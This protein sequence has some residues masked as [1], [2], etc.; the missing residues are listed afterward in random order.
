MKDNLQLVQ[1]RVSNDKSWNIGE[2]IESVL[3]WCGGEVTDLG[4]VDMGSSKVVEST[5]VGETIELIV[6]KRRGVRGVLHNNK[7]ICAKCLTGIASE[8]V[9]LDQDLIVRSGVDS[10]ETEVLVVVV[11]QMLVSKATSVTTCGKVAPVV[12]V[13]SQMKLAAINVAKFV[14][15]SNERC[16]VM[17]VKVVPGD[18]NP[19]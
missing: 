16:L 4:N 10:L 14:V 15:V 3:V 18:G 2:R 8:D 1:A 12:V 11:I 19:I 6:T 7:T 13:V 5:E 9:T 17:V